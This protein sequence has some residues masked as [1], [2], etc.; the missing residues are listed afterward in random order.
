LAAGVEEELNHGL[1]VAVHG[2][3]TLLMFLLLVTSSQ[4]SRLLHIFHPIIF[5]LTYFF[6]GLIY[7]F[8]GG[9]DR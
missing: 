7:F 6:F 8:A 4:P 3:N 9:V 1:D 2:I 5:A